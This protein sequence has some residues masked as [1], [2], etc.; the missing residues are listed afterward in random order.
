MVITY[1]AIPCVIVSHVVILHLHIYM[2]GSL[3]V[4]ELPEWLLIIT[5]E[6]LRT[7]WAHTIAISYYIIYKIQFTTVKGVCVENA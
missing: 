2:C 7:S 3:T 5:K 1:V 4:T 6:W